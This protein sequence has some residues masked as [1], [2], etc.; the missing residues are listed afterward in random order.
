MTIGFPG[1]NYPEIISPSIVRTLLFKFAT[2]INGPNRDDIYC[3]HDESQEDSP[4]WHLSVPNLLCDDGK[5]NDNGLSVA[6]Q[7]MEYLNLVALHT[8]IPAYHHQA[9][10]RYLVMSLAWMSFLLVPMKAVLM[11]SQ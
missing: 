2:A 10:S 9:T 4:D 3:C 11:S 5:H 7:L 6:N 1:S 8:V